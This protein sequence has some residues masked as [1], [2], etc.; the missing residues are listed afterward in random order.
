MR[1]LSAEGIRDKCWQ[2]TICSTSGD[3]LCP[4]SALAPPLPS[5]NLKAFFHNLQNLL[6][7]PAL[8]RNTAR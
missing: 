3:P 1:W 5:N 7:A 2:K 4:S 6:A 8:P